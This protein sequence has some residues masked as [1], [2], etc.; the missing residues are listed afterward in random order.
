MAE[1]ETAAQAE[2]AEVARELTA[3]RYRLLGV[4]ASLGPKQE[5]AAETDDDP[6]VATEVRSVVE[7]VLQDSIR[8]AITDLLAASQYSPEGERR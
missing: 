1:L 5:G 8:P 3:L 6:D 7:C 2:V 4:V